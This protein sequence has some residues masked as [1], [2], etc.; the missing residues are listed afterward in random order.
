MKIQ[1][2]YIFLNDVFNTFYAKHDI[3]VVNLCT[4]GTVTYPVGKVYFSSKN[5][6]LY[7]LP[8]DVTPEDKTWKV[9]YD[10]NSGNLGYRDLLNVLASASTIEE[11]KEY[12]SLFIRLIPGY[13]KMIGYDQNNDYHQYTL[14]DHSLHTVLNIPKYIDDD[15]LYLAALIHDIGKPEARC[16]G[17]KQEDTKS[18]YYGHPEKSY[19]YTKNTI[20]PF[21][22]DHGYTFKEGEKEKLLYYVRYHD[23]NLSLKPKHLLHHLR[24]VDF[25]TFKKLMVLQIA[26]AKAHVMY[27]IIFERI[28]TCMQWSG[29]YGEKIYSDIKNGKIK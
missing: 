22:E 20:I 5:D 15:M 14:E 4:E 3:K 9:L 10:P 8:A 18:H 28:R 24:L 12:K 16:K 25:E 11:L 23:D 2:G 13:D 7:L 27:P 1:V 17:R 6:E 26:D 29:G 21:M 19:E